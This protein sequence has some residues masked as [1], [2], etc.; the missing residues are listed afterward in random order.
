MAG[1]RHSAMEEETKGEVGGIG[2]KEVNST[3]R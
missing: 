3:K 2:T 1:P